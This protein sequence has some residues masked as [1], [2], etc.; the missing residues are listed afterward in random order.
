M[1]PEQRDP[2]PRLGERKHAPVGVFQ[3]GEYEKGFSPRVADGGK[4]F[5]GVGGGAE[6]GRR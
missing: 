3:V 4:A 1:A 6:G 5:R 2:D